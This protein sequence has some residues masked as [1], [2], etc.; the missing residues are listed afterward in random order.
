MFLFNLISNALNKNIYEI[1]LKLFANYD[2]N[3]WMAV[4]YIIF[5]LHIFIWF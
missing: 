2:N 3:Y 5:L 1:E 4:Y